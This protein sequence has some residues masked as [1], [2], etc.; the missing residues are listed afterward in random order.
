MENGIPYYV[1][2]NK[3]MKKSQLRQIIKEEIKKTI[4][5]GFDWDEHLNKGKE[6]KVEDLKKEFNQLIK[7]HTPTFDAVIPGDGEYKIVDILR[8]ELDKYEKV[9]Y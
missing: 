2:I 3:N 8:V 7:K 1:K 6:T 9:P 4:K 5:E